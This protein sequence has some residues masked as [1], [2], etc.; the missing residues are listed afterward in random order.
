MNEVTLVYQENEGN[1]GLE[2]SKENEEDEGNLDFPDPRVIQDS[3]VHQAQLVNKVS[4][5]Q[6]DHLDLQV[7]RDLQ[8]LMEKMELLGH[9]VNVVLLVSQETK[10]LQVHRG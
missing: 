5:D 4:R 9:L 2:A 10:G 3:Q 6:K 1:K 8:D 7:N